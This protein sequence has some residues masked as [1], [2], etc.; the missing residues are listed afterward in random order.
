MSTSSPT[1]RSTAL[2]PTA[3]LTYPAPFQYTDRGTKALYIAQKYA[4]LLRS[5]V[6]DIGCDEKQLSK[7]LPSTSRYTGVDLNPKADLQIN[8]DL[9]DTTLPFKDQQFEAVVACDVLEHLERIHAIFD[10]LCRVSS[11]RVILS[12]QNPLRCLMQA[13]ATG[14]NGRTKFY[15]LPLDV[16][17]DRHRWFFGAEEAEAFMRDRGSRN[18]FTVEQMDFED[19]GAPFWADKHGQNRLSSRNAQLGTCWCVL[20]RNG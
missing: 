2:T 15:G 8:L 13:I 16:P 10:E 7:H 19:E 12:L 14:T 20:R 17:A 4:P 11:S 18:G 6:L 3:A 5:T 9:P 1:S